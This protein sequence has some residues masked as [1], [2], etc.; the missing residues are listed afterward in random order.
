MTENFKIG[1]SGQYS[2]KLT[3]QRLC[4]L[5]ELEWSVF[6]VG[7]PDTGIYNPKVTQAVWNIVSG[8]PGH[9]D[10]FPYI[11]QWLRLNQHPAPWLEKCIK[12][13]G[14]QVMLAGPKKGPSAPAVLPGPAEDQELPPPYSRPSGVGS[15]HPSPD[16]TNDQP[17]SPLHTRSGAPH[18]PELLPL[19]EAPPADGSSRGRPFFVHIPFS[20]SD[21]YNWKAQHAPFSEKPQALAGLLE[22]VF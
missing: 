2:V 10:Q 5:S 4:T 9:P 16:S 7:R 6:G 1:F 8:S 15:R 17:L 21:L 18:P 22:S 19:R 14:L 12:C 11:N 3:P 20:S 13:A